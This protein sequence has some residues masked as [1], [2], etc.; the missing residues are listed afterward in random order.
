ML[1]SI[2]LCACWPS[3][4]LLWGNVY[5]GLLPVFWL[6]CLCFLYKA[7]WPVYLFWKL[8]PCQWNH[9]QIFSPGQ[10]VFILFIVSLISKEI[11]PVSPKGN[12]SWIFIGRTDTEAE[13]PILWPLDAKNWLIEKTLILGKIEGKKRRRWQRMRW[14]DSITDSMDMSLNKLH[15]WVMGRETW[16]APVHRVA[17]SWTWLSDWT[18]LIVSFVVQKL[19][20]FYLFIFLNFHHSKRWIQVK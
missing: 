8:I 15:E 5:L 7:V 9:L 12:Q 13:A 4:C 17:K 10:Y 19:I 1:L 18:E 14:L 2:F 6:D 16:H 11:K 3:V 20:R